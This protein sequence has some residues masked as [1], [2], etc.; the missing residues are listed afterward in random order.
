MTDDAPSG[1]DR[2]GAPRPASGAR[3][4]AGGDGAGA[5]TRLVA[6]G[7]V[8]VFLPLPS[9]PTIINVYLI[10][11]GDG[12]WALVDTGVAL[13]ASAAAFRGALAELGID[14]AAVTHLLA[15]HHHP[16]HF[17]ASRA[18]RA[19]IGGVVHL[20]PAE[21]ER[22]DYTLNAGAEDMVR[23][24]RRH[25]IPVPAEPVEAPKPMQVWAGTF[26]PTTEVQ[27][28]LRDGEVLHIGQR[29]FQVVWTPG[30]TPGHCCFLELDDR[31]MFVGDHLLP[32]ITPHVGVY[33]TGPENPLADFLASQEKVA[34]LDVA[35][36]CPAHGAVFT[37]HRHRARQ[38]I[39][40]HEVRAREMWDILQ[41]G[42]ASAYAV[43]RKAF[44]WV[45]DNANDRF[46]AGAAVM[47]TIAHLEL[48]RGR[49]AL[50]RED[51]AGVWEYRVVPGSVG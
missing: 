14:P 44:R 10:D 36:V 24:S 1:N 39:A 38:L 7:V 29:R 4:S 27:H 21:L 8:E 40:H 41:S 43:A 37:D 32:R 15:T 2:S 50:R 26:Q 33:A 17:G 47:E 45:F 25:G 23:H 13:P 46:Q 34:A 20:H 49:G 51:V 48:L 18:Y 35:L 19:E 12:S 16:D 42:P 11:C 6:R 22:I 28:L 5:K 9:K 3:R 31:V 30:H